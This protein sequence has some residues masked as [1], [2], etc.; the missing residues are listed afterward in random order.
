[1]Q[2]IGP[3]GERGK[4]IRDLEYWVKMARYLG[5]E[6]LRQAIMVEHARLVR[7]QQA[8]LTDLE[9]AA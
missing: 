5:Y 3:I 9:L 2:T 6:P 1:V 4:K 7:E 8:L